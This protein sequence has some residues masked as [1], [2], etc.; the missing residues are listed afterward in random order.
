[1][2]RFLKINENIAVDIFNV[3][4]VLTAHSRNEGFLMDRAPRTRVVLRLHGETCHHVDEFKTE[5][6]AQKEVSR[7]VGLLEKAWE[8]L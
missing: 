3:Q 2:K 8:K 7:I 4:A 6:L 5:R 1:M